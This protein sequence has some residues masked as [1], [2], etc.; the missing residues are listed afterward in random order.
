VVAAGMKMINTMQGMPKAIHGAQ[1]DEQSREAAAVFAESVNILLRMLAPIV[2]HMTHTL[3]RGLNFGEHILD[4]PWPE[5]DAKALQ[6]DSVEMGV[7]VNGKLRAKIDVPA[8]AD[9]TQIEVIALS[10]DNVARHIEGKHVVKVVV[11]PKRLVNIV[12]K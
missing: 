9:K 5:P 6:S 11:V 2:P 3:W 4:A 12:V 1:S 7:Q 8:Q 10:E